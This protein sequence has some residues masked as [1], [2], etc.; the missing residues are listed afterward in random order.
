[1]RKPIS[2]SVRFDV[3][4]RFNFKCAYCGIGSN[5]SVLEIDHLKPVS[6]GG[7]NDFL[8]LVA[9]CRECNRGKYNKVLDWVNTFTIDSINKDEIVYIRYLSEITEQE[10]SDLQEV[11][12]LFKNEFP[13]YHV[14]FENQSRILDYIVDLGFHETFR[15]MQQAIDFPKVDNTPK[16]TLEYF[17][18]LS[19]EE[20]HNKTNNRESWEKNQW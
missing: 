20:L 3:L 5:E 10:K 11:L 9:C 7:T 12:Q 15:C 19:N 4:T 17:F 13:N 14:S 16:Y 8:N 6:R 2:N 18:E 1:M